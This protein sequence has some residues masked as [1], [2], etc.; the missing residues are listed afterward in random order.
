[1]G[2]WSGSETS[3]KQ[4]NRMTPE[5][6]QWLQQLESGQGLQ[7]ND[8]Y[9][10]GSSY[11]SGLMNMSPEAFQQYSAPEMRNFNEQIAPGIANRYGGM[12]AGSSSAMNQSMAQAGTGLQERLAALRGGL[13]QKGAE[14]ALG[15]AS[16]PYEQM[17]QGLGAS[18]Y[19][20][21][22]LQGQPGVGAGFMQG[23]GSGI[24]RAG[25]GVLTGGLGGA[26]SS[27]YSLVQPYLSKSYSGG[28]GAAPS[29]GSYSTR[30]PGSGTSGKWGLP[31]AYGDY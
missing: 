15:Y 4:M 14:M 26:A 9:K 13:Q 11:L 21:L 24:G 3:V 8:L 17:I 22:V 25:M 16:R 28:G 6:M 30:G 7:Q 29:Y 5:M 18:P 20:N 31:T 23:L 12:G 1:M 27:L 19:E 2:W 10:Q